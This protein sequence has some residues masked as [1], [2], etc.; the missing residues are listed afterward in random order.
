MGARSRSTAHSEAARPS[1]TPSTITVPAGRCERGSQH[2]AIVHIFVCQ[3]LVEAIRPDRGYGTSSSERPIP[4]GRRLPVRLKLE[5]TISS[6]NPRAHAARCARPPVRRSC[7]RCEVFGVFRVCP[8][9]RAVQ[10]GGRRVIFG[11]RL[12]PVHM[13]LTEE[14]GGSSP[15]TAEH[16]GISS[17]S[18]RD[19]S[20][21]YAT[22]PCACACSCTPPALSRIRRAGTGRAKRRGKCSGQISSPSS[23]MGWLLV[24]RR[25]RAFDSS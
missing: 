7:R 19:A 1:T 14:R 24:G 3:D 6:S 25:R 18:A 20:V 5:A 11:R 15:M 12:W 13:A 21:R 23:G 8:G 2:I 10:V 4:Y 22:T 9:R 17:C 16:H